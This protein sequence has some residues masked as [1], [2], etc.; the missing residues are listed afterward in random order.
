[1]ALWDFR[2]KGDIW[3]GVAIGVGVIAAPVVIP[4][5]WS[6][7]RPLFKAVVKGGF[8]VYERG[9][10]IVEEAIEGTTDFVEEAKS[11][12]HDELSAARKAAK[13]SKPAKS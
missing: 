12:V 4:L 13:T 11:E 1:M 2:P 7:I 9:R 8:M 6:G 3:T 5:I 10:E